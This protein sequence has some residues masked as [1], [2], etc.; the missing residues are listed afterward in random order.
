MPIANV[1]A[2]QVKS[3]DILFFSAIT[4][5]IFSRALVTSEVF[6]IENVQVECCTFRCRYSVIVSFLT[7]A[8]VGHVPYTG[9]FYTVCHFD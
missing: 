1:C 5:Y 7:E 9:W 6:N 3:K 8:R 4:I 2:L